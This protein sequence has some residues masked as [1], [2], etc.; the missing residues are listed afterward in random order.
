[1]AQAVAPAVKKTVSRTILITSARS[2]PRAAFAV[3]MPFIE[4]ILVL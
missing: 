2:V 1:M 4:Q 3:S